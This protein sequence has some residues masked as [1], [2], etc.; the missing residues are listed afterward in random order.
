MDRFTY[1]IVGGGTA[2]ANAVDGIRAHDTK[3]SIALFGREN[4]LPYDRPPLSKGL[5]LGK[6]TEEQLPV[7]DASFYESSGVQLHLGATIDR[8][9][10]KERE[11]V[12]EGGRAYRYDK[13]L[14][15][16]GGH[17]RPLQ[18]GEG[19][20][21]YL[22]TVDDYHSLL[23]ASGP[24][25]T[26]V[27]IGGG[28]IGCEISASLTQKGMH[29]T[30]IFPETDILSHMLPADLAAHVTGYYR[31]KGVTIESGDIPV[32]LQLGPDA[33]NVATREHKGILGDLVVGAVG[34]A[35][36]TRIAASAGLAIGNGIIVDSHLQTSEPFI[37]AAGDVAMFPSHAL[38]R[39]V[40]VEHWDN[41]RAQGFLAGENMAGAKKP[42]DYLPYF[43]SDLF[44]LGFEAVGDISSR[45][46]VYADWKDKFREG[47]L[48]YLDQGLVK[49]VLLWN[50]WEK[51]PQARALVEQKTKVMYPSELSGRI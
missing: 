39:N 32:S 46:E 21:A 25:R 3:G 6:T 34:L 29:V 11:V 10:P 40:R 12:D 30:M 23:K 13:L 44:D 18:F 51:V 19:I 5:W 42:Y 22:R 49:G 48:Y 15:A 28:F 31:S 37:F 20:V 17:A 45:L 9:M 4:H 38:G 43:Y 24:S 1:I 27:V 14:I 50:V 41:A 8:V 2:G 16:T 26:V 33:I 35:L 47:V 7:H 36:D